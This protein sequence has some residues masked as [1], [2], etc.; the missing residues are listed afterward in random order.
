M[1]VVRCPFTPKSQEHR[2]SARRLV[3]QPYANCN[4][5][6]APLTQ[7]VNADDVHRLRTS[8]GID[9]P[10]A[11]ETE[12][13][14]TLAN[15]AI[16]DKYGTGL[17]L[18]EV[19]YS[20]QTILRIPPLGLGWIEGREA[21]VRYTGDFAIDRSDTTSKLTDVYFDSRDRD[22]H[23][24]YWDPASA[25]LTPKQASEVCEDRSG[26]VPVPASYVTIKQ[27]GHDGA[28]TLVGGR[29]STVM[30]ARG[31]NDIVRGG[32]GND[33]LYGGPGSDLLS[34][35][36][37]SDTIVDSRGRARVLAGGGGRSGRDIVDVRDGEGDDIVTCGNRIARVSADPGDRLRRC[38]ER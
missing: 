22:D 15:Q 6:G 13:I 35:G 4:A 32:P 27:R 23:H 33:R 10:K 38:G 11:A 3:G 19:P 28:D 24:L 37:G 17:E 14:F 36:P 9:D 29:E 5:V 25:L 12:P 1:P 16:K 18:D 34:G 7:T 31:G 2:F 8:F 20:G 26:P 30:I 21:I